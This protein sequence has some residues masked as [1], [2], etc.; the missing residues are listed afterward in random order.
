MYVVATYSGENSQMIRAGRE[1][2]HSV[3][4]YWESERVGSSM[5]EI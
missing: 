2:R 5:I 4:E 1:S 3:Q